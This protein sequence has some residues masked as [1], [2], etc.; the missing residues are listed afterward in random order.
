MLWWKHQQLR[1][2]GPKTRLAVVE[3][4]AEAYDTNVVGSLI[5]ALN[6]KE[7]EVRCAAAKALMRY[8]DRRAVEPL[9]QVLRDPV[10]LARAAAAE[11]LGRLGDPQAVNPL[12]GLLRDAD[13][14]VRGIAARSL[15]RLGWK[16]GTDSQR[17]LHILAAGNLRQLAALGSDGVEH[18]LEVLR[19]GTPNKQFSAVKA[20]G[21]IS[22]PR[23]RPAMLEALKNPTPAVRI[24]ALG[25]VEHLADPA[26]FPEVEKMLEDGNASVRGAAVEAATVCG[27]VRAV[28]SLVKCLKDTSWEVRKEAAASLGPLGDASAVKGLCAL[29][30]DPDRDVRESAI[31][32][33]GQLRD[34]AALLPLVPLLLDPETQV[35]NAA[36]AALRAIDPGWAD[37]EVVFEAV[38]KIKAALNHPEYWVRHCAGKLLEQLKIDTDKSPEGSPAAARLTLKTPPHPAFAALSEMLFDGDRDVRL[39]AAVSLG[40]L[41]EPNAAPLLSNAV[42]DA[43]FSVRQAVLSALTALN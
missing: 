9:I 35:R 36:A 30:Q 1:L 13:P 4:L 18:L 14:I 3:K 25:V 20:M 27:G 23:V 12:A 11:T 7:A 16:P 15:N 28:P 33:L 26:T 2:G 5:F 22:D 29:L 19:N 42:R 39:A 40:R 32:A 6:D 41:R 10:P 43:D 38:P 17:V 8:Q 34:R 24:A 21:G 37:A 31:H